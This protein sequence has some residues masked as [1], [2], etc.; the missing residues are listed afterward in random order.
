MAKFFKLVFDELTIDHGSDILLKENHM[1]IN[2]N[3]DRVREQLNYDE[4]LMVSEFP[5]FKLPEDLI[6]ELTTLGKQAI[7]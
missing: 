2:I 6:N 4:S 5:L 1:I 3:A 7:P